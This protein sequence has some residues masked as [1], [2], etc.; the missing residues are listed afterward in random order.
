MLFSDSS[1]RFT[2]GLSSVSMETDSEGEG[3]ESEE[4]D[5]DPYPL[6]GKYAD[7]ADRQRCV[8]GH[9][10]LFIIQRRLFG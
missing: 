6:D 3:P 2:L 5:A 1:P 9:A 10:A 4:E 8:Y 7:E